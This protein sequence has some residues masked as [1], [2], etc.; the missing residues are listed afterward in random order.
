M[1]HPSIALYSYVQGQLYVTINLTCLAHL[2]VTPNQS[3]LLSVHIRIWRCPTSWDS[4]WWSLAQATH[5]RPSD[6]G[7]DTAFSSRRSRWKHLSDYSLGAT[8]SYLL[9]IEDVEDLYLK[10]GWT[11]GVMLAHDIKSEQ[12][13]SFRR[14]H[15]PS[16]N[17]KLCL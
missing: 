15:L 11:I 12:W 17:Y 3:R 2:Y 8:L 9:L 13:L 4:Y 1:V 5:I 14:S 7:H 6:T 10:G 16:Q